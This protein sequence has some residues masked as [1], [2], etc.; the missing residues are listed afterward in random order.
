MDGFRAGTRYLWDRGWSAAVLLAHLPREDGSLKV[1]AGIS[2]GEATL[3]DV[4]KALGE[5]LTSE[6]DEL[7]TKGE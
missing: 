6:E 3:I 2:A 7:R 1:C 5:Y 4:V